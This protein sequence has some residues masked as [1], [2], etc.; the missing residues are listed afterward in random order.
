MRFFHSGTFVVFTGRFF[1]FFHAHILRFHGWVLAENFTGTVDFS[2]AVSNN[3]SREGFFF[4]GRKSKKF[5]G[6]EFFF[7]GEKKKHCARSVPK[8]LKAVFFFFPVKEKM[9][10][11]KI[12][13][14]P[15]VKKKSFPW[16]SLGNCPWKINSP[17]EI[18][19]KSH[20]WKRRMWA[21]KEKSAGENH[22]SVSKKKSHTIS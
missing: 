4:H 3:F 16:K 12:F 8:P 10:P 20:P 17:R 9:P 14:F 7:H 13:G 11:V 19:A 1:Y 2:R 18:S 15:P 5:H 6:R 21:W 22:E